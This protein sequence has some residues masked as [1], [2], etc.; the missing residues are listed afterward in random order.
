MVLMTNFMLS[1]ICVYVEHLHVFQSI[2]QFVLFWF[3]WSFLNWPISRFQSV[4]ILSWP[5]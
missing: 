2:V 5:D 3:D 4:Y 1:C